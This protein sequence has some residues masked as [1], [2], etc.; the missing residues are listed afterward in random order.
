M[1]LRPY[2]ATDIESLLVLWWESW[3]SSAS[4]QHPKPLSEWRVRWENILQ[5]HTVVVAESNGTLV[6]F[7]ALDRERAV[8][9][10]LFVAP[11]AK[12]QGIGR[13][14]FNWAVS[15]CPSRLRLK[16]LLKTPKRAFYKSYGM[17][18]QDRSVN[19]FSGRE[20]IEYAL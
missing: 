7:A 12:R 19:D 10:Q 16:T 9:S 3:H 20:E 8:L 17:V 4:F 11:S 15:R 1:N 13:V 18:E 2:Q 6:G 5:N 14:L